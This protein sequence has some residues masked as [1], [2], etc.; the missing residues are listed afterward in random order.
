MPSMASTL[1]IISHPLLLYVRTCSR[2]LLFLLYV[3]K[4]CRY[5]VIVILTQLL[6]YM[7]ELKNGG[8]T[9]TADRTSRLS[10]LSM[11]SS[12]LTVIIDEYFLSSG[13]YLCCKWVPYL[14]ENHVDGQSKTNIFASNYLECK[15]KSVC[16][17]EK[18]Y[19]FLNFSAPYCRVSKI[20]HPTCRLVGIPKYA[21]EWPKL[22]WF[23]STP[24]S[25]IP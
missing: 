4:N 13:A 16:F 24:S 22:P 12:N 25:V 3:V 23:H 1:F 5:C 6:Q 11:F 18:T 21:P 14:C 17:D 7:K 15:T 10:H 20:Q 19:K 2:Y 8:P 9:V